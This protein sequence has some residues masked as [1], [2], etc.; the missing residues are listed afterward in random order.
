MDFEEFRKQKDKKTHGGAAVAV[1][2][3]AMA[4]GVPA[5]SRVERKTIAVRQNVADKKIARA[6]AAIPKRPARGSWQQENRKGDSTLNRHKPAAKEAL[7][8]ERKAGYR[9]LND[10]KVARRAIKPKVYPKQSKLWLG[11]VGVGLPLS[12]AGAMHQAKKNEKFGKA[13]DRKDT[14]AAYAGGAGA[15]LGYQG[16]VMATKP[17][18][19][20]NE[21]KIKSNPG[22][23]KKMKAHEDKYRPKGMTA[24]DPRFR[25]FFRNY[26][27]DLPGGKMKRT[28]AVTHTGKSGGAITLGLG[29]AGATAAVHHSRKKRGISKSDTMSA[30]G[31]DHG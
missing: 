21:K 24:G 14:T 27:K 31:V 20:K 11:A 12:Y 10:L 1:G 13:M 23:R 18:D 7:R 5:V 8:A 2:G 29:A 25:Q 17:L 4:L 28:L 19:W 3:G 30:F 22:M 26:P 9:K 6:E 15:M 16:G